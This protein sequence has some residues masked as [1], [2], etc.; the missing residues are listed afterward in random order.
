MSTLSQ[1]TQ[2]LIMVGQILESSLE[3]IERILTTYDAEIIS[4]NE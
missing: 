1:T 2:Q 4:D 3:R